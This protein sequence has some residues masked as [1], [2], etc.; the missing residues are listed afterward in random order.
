MPIGKRNY[1]AGDRTAHEQCNCPFWSKN[2]QKQ[3]T[4]FEFCLTDGTEN[5]KNMSHTEHPLWKNQT[6]RKCPPQPINCKDRPQKQLF[7]FSTGHLLVQPFQRIPPQWKNNPTQGSKH[8]LWLLLPPSPPWPNQHPC[9]WAASPRKTTTAHPGV[10][11]Q[12]RAAQVLVVADF[13]LRP[14]RQLHH[15]RTWVAHLHVKPGMDQTAG[16]VIFMIMC[17]VLL[18]EGS[19]PVYLLENTAQQ[20]GAVGLQ[21]ELRS[22][23][24]VESRFEFSG[25][26]YRIFYS[27][28]RYSGI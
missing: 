21:H 7:R 14:T 23:T 24:G 15:S 13:P 28:Y 8:Y 10:P 4:N 25:S 19:L 3:T 12:P 17:I 20:L 1:V 22:E 26:K 6:N 5:R 18:Y 11:R 9:N 16:L 27:F 2:Q